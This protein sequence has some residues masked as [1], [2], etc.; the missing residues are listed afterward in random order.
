MAKYTNQITINLD[1]ETA[2]ALQKL[3]QLQQRK[4]AELVRLLVVPV[5]YKELAQA[6]NLG[7]TST[8]AHFTPST[9]DKLP[10]M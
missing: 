9:F 10:K 7:S 3:A 5:I 2:E 8:P 1:D 4:P 6:V